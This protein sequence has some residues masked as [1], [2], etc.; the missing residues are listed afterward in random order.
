MRLTGGMEKFLCTTCP[1]MFVCE[2]DIGK[3]SVIL[4]RIYKKSF[5]VHFFI[6]TISG[7]D[8]PIDAPTDESTDRWMDQPTDKGMN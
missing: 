4:R 2:Y 3:I 7:T 6:N 8:R 1:S 5:F